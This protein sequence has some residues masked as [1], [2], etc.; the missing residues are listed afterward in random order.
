MAVLS[1]FTLLFVWEAVS[2]GSAARPQSQTDL[3]SNLGLV[4][5]K[6]CGVEQVAPFP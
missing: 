3:G 6:L 2:M 1:R 5:Y 4:A